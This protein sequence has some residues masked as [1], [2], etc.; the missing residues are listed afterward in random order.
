[1]KTLFAPFRS[2]NILSVPNGAQ[3]WN[4]TR[5][6]DFGLD[7]DSDRHG[8]VVINQ[9]NRLARKDVHERISL[10]HTRLI[11]GILLK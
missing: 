6:P 10:F 3:K 8:K 2:R 5:A 11:H 7:L 1:M 4:I 9:F